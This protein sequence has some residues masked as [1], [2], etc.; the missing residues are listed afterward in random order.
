MYT[1][2]YMNACVYIYLCCEAVQEDPIPFMEDLK[3]EVS[4]IK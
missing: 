1:V 4:I 2:L 3:Q